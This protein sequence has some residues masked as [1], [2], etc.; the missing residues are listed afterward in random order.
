MSDKLPVAIYKAKDEIDSQ[1]LFDS[2]TTKGYTVQTI[3]I[4]DQ[5]WNIHL[6]FQRYSSKIRW[7][8]FI[9]P[10]VDQSAEAVKYDTQPNENIVIFFVNKSNDTIYMV[11]AGSAYFSIAEYIDPE[12]GISVLSRI[13]SKDAK[14]I[15]S[16]KEQSIA[17]GIF[18]EIKFFRQNYNIYENETFGSFYQE[19]ITS[20]DKDILKTQLGFSDEEVKNEGLCIAKNSFKITKSINFSQLI[21]IIN[22]FEN[23]ISS[24]HPIEINSVR[25]LNRTIDKELINQLKIKLAYSLYCNYRNHGT[26]Y[27]Y[28]LCHSEFE[29]YLT[30]ST[31]QIAKGSTLYNSDIVSNLTDIKQVFEVLI[32]RDGLIFSFKDFVIKYKDLKIV[33]YDDNSQIRTKGKLVSHVI[34]DLS[35][36]N[37]KYFFIDNAWYLINPSYLRELNEECTNFINSTYHQQSII[38]WGTLKIT[39]NEYN[40][41]YIGR[42]DTL[43]LDKV[44]CEKIEICDFLSWDNDSIYL[45][46][47]KIGFGNT[48]RD[49]CSQ[50][51]ISAHRLKR[52]LASGKS[53]L[54]TY[55]DFLKNKVG[56]DPYFNSV[57]LQ[58]KTITKEV[59]LKLFDKKIIFVLVVQDDVKK[60]RS[61]KNI[62]KYGSNIAKISIAELYKKMKGIDTSLEI[63]QV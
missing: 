34:A 49:L 21:G 7:K 32:N 1:E 33:S 51:F 55:Y 44:L 29:K 31:Y 38:P 6:Y 16:T 25:K 59:F 63:V 3:T 10:I 20:I 11:T 8:E 57:G 58:T 46:H 12:F 15:K 39:E 13:I 50:I 43:V 9:R 45:Y 47:V 56:K 35:F 48:M 27:N 19:L 2:L 24:L 30:A 36:V 37:D 53:F 4:T 52:D 61:I 40:A 5:T 23:I 17:G 26:Y 42:K 54:S 14:V 62:E 60:S 28:D 41:K 22:G 18:G